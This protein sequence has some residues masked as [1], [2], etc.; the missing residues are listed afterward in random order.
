MKVNKSLGIKKPMKKGKTTNVASPFFVPAKSDK[1][2]NWK[3]ARAKYPSMKPNQDYDGDGF[4]NSIDCKPMDI[5]RDGV[6]GRL[7]NVITG[8]RKGQSA[9][10]YSRERKEKKE[11]RVAR[12]GVGKI[13][14]ERIVPTRLQK[15]YK[16]YKERIFFM[17]LFPV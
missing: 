16:E 13:P 4:I 17:D 6:F 7:A 1:N 10:D 15:K 9:E 5:T 2:L 8:G 14:K 3:Q 11:E 12:S